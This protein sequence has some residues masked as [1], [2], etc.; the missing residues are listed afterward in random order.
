MYPLIVR[1]T[2]LVWFIALFL[3]VLVA[4]Y[5]AAGRQ[6]FP[7]VTSYKADLEL[8]LTEQLSVPVS[9]GSIQGSWRW[10]DPVL[11]VSDIKLKPPN[12][13]DG[14]AGYES[15]VSSP[16]HINSFYIHLNEYPLSYFLCDHEV[17]HM[18]EM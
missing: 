17:Y 7:F 13:L 14:G 5:M 12:D 18:V 15:S 16:L 9:I 10:L 2:Q 3:L 11:I 1:F 6:F 4:T 8:L